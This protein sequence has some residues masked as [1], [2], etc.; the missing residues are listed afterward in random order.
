MRP[1]KKTI[2]KFRAWDTKNK[3][4]IPNHSL[5]YFNGIFESNDDL[6]IMRYIGLHDKNGVEIY[7]GDIVGTK[8]IYHFLERDGWKPET[9]N[10]KI[11]GEK[12]RNFT[13]K[14]EEKYIQGYRLNKVEWRN[15]SCGFEPFADS[16]DNCGHCGGGELPKDWMVLG[17]TYQN[18]G[19][20]TNSIQKPKKRR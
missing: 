18:P 19:L 20:I 14:R 10:W 3:R 9:G 5:S 1:S 17:N 2:I 16:K 12:V 6:I 7:E 15:E 13:G 8:E 4:M 11:I